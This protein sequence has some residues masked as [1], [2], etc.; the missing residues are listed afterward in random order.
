MAHIVLY[1]RM[2]F[3][4]GERSCMYVELAY[5]FK[6]LFV[7]EKNYHSRFKFSELEMSELPPSPILA[8]PNSFPTEVVLSTLV[9]AFYFEPADCEYIWYDTGVVMPS[10]KGRDKLISKFP[11]KV[12]LVKR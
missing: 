3:L 10:V 9:E 8:S 6:S 7:S 1:F 4:G 12:S 2:T 11:V 5:S